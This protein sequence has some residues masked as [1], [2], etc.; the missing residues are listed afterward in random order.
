MTSRG[1]ETFYDD[2][3]I[4]IYRAAETEGVGINIHQ[5]LNNYQCFI[6]VVRVRFCVCMNQ[7]KVRCRCHRISPQITMTPTSYK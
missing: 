6:T 2:R 3:Y 7:F 4:E 5:R 1:I